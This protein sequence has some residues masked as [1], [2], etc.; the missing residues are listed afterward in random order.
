[1]KTFT[2]S[3]IVDKLLDS[4]TS[5]RY[6]TVGWDVNTGQILARQSNKRLEKA[7]TA[8]TKVVKL[9]K[10]RNSSADIACAVFKISSVNTV[11]NSLSYEVN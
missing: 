6:H 4:K 2:Y 3:D 7:V 5:T 1:M 8:I 10:N 11:S 9:S